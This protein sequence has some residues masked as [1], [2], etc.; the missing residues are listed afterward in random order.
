MTFHGR[1]GVWTQESP[2]DGPCGFCG[3]PA[4]LMVSETADGRQSGPWCSLAH[5]GHYHDRAA[6]ITGRVGPLVDRS[7]VPAWDRVVSGWPAT[8]EAGI[9]QDHDD[10]GD[11]LLFRTDDGALAGVL[12]HRNGRIGVLVDP[13]RRRQGIGKALLRAAGR[14]WAIHLGGQRVTGPGV[15]LIRAALPHRSTDA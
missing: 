3:Q 12:W 4:S 5:W 13:D 14:R 6:H 10:R 11:V 8:G 15:E 9:T 2:P 1:A 7:P